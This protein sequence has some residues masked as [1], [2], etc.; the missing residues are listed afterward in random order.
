[1]LA[2]KKA[3]EIGLDINAGHDLNLSNLG[4]FSKE[5][6]GL[7]EVSI[8]HAIISDALYLGLENTIQMYK[9]LLT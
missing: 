7:A 1:M 4:F 5:I 3:T 8:G 9:R 6:K 2:A